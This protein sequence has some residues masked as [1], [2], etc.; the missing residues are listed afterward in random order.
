MQF[1]IKILPQEKTLLASAGQTLK[2][3]LDQNNIHLEG[4]CGGQG[5]CGSCSLFI[6]EPILDNNTVSPK[7]QPAQARKTEYIEINGKKI[8]AQQVLACQT[9][10]EQDMA[11][12]L[13]ASQPDGQPGKAR[14]LSQVLG[15]NKT[16]PLNP[17]V[18]IGKKQEQFFLKHK[19]KLIR[20]LKSW[21]QGA[22]PLGAAIDLGTT[23][24]V[25][26]L[27]DLEQGRILAVSSDLNPQQAFG[28]DVLSRI[29]HA[30]T[31]QGRKELHECISTGLSRLIKKV[32]IQAQVRPTWVLEIV[33]G[34]N[35]TMLELAAGIDPTP[36]GHLPFQVDIQGGHNY[37]VKDFGLLA[38]D[39]ATIYLPPIIHAFV[40]TDIS[41]GL[42]VCPEF[43]NPQKKVLFLDLGTNGEIC[44]N[45]SGRKFATSTAAGPA[46][47][48]V[49]LSAGMRAL[50]GAMEKIN[51]QGKK[52][53][54]KTID[55][56]PI[57]GICGSGYIS[58]LA[59]LLQTGQLDPSGRLQ[60]PEK[61][62]FWITKKAKITQKDIRQLQL[63]KGAVRTGIDLLLEHG[64]VQPSDLDQIFLAGGFGNF[65]APQDLERIGLLP[66]NTSPKVKFLGNTSLNGAIKLLLHA[67]LRARLEKKC[68]SIAHVQLAN[69]KKFM[70][71]FVEN[72]AFPKTD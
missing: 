15:D 41:A 22:R 25:V 65:V 67:D 26:S 37:P 10:I 72:L 9:K 4:S 12:S 38:N 68:I 48:G 27:V 46:F 8:L 17:A 24:L 19:N 47:E 66:R 1:K 49:G 29:Q 31:P 3:V 52:I 51:L 53:S 36:L 50:P 61:D 13:E 21:S 28:H 43:F 70:N 32:C 35:T 23:T 44:L 30:A 55:D 14:I 2:E 6:L 64:Q 63:A 40:G 33:L 39:Q 34:A 54:Y 45:A 20:P 7:N 57:Q 11:I 5:I 58:L 42:L 71:L 69:E 60:S 18:S 62:S 59:A 16:S 56:Q